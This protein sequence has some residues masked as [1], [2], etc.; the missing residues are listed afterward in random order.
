MND[1]PSLTPDELARACANEMW[2]DDN[3][4]RGL[5]MEIME[6]SSGRAVLQ[7]RIRE[8]MTNGHKICH[9]GFIFLLADSAFAYACNSY[10]Q[11]TV[12]QH[13]SVDFLKPTHQGDLLVA[14]AVER[15]KFGRSGIYDVTI[16][17]D[18]GGVVAEFR[19]NSRT[20]KGQYL[21]D[22]KI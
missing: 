20:I 10:N 5:G 17:L 18:G 6:I 22:S 2:N 9:G 21:P 15:H 14:T 8:D 19:G 13:C 7:M 12:A 4:T 16:E 3:A 1:M 11:Y